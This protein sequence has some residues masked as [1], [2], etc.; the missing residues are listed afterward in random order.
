MTVRGLDYWADPGHRRK[1]ETNH[2]DGGRGVY[3][4]DPAGHYLVIISIR[5]GEGR[6]EPTAAGLIL[7][8]T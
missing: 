6:V 8:K 1:G 7:P 2:N 3:F 4:N 5:P